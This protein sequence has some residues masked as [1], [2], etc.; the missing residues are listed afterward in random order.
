MTVETN[1]E[2]ET[3]VPENLVAALAKVQAEIPDV[4][5]SKIGNVR[6]EKANYSYRYADL[7]AV[8]DAILP[9]L[10]RNGLAWVT[11]PLMTER[12]FVLRYTL[13][14]SSGEKITGDYPLPDPSRVGPQQVGSAL[15]YARRYC[16][17]AVTG[18]APGEDDD[19]AAAA[20]RNWADYPTD[21][22]RSSRGRRR[23]SQAGPLVPADDAPADR[24]SKTDTP[25][26]ARKREDGEPAG[27]NSGKR[28][29]EGAHRRLMAMFSGAGFKDTET[30][31]ARRLRVCSTIVGR[32]VTS[33][34]DDLTE[35][36]AR[37]IIAG[38]SEHRQDV[39]GWLGTLLDDTAVEGPTDDQHDA[40][41]PGV[42][43]DQR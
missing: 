21:Q 16:L 34:A 13:L 7:S 30:D 19:D 15:T 10:G 41:G 9:L 17:C 22:P 12:G 31:R 33:T 29:T 28:P 39:S 40:P 3:T 32:T 20:Q 43:H 27:D 35:P 8:T 38:F 2:T 26:R 11:Q 42:D 1:T 6:S 18:V 23:S 37:K 14:H 24:R 5:K 25:A 4:E 36:E